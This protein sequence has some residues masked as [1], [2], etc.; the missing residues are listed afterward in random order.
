MSASQNCGCACPTPEVVEVPGTPGSDGA[1]GSDGLNAFTSVATNFTVP[2]ADGATP[3]TVPVY[4][5]T[6]MVVGQY[7]FIQSAGTFQVVSKPGASS[8]IL[9]YANIST[10][11]QAGST[12]SAGAG[13]S[14][15]GPPPS[16]ALGTIPITGGGTGATSKS[17]AQAALGLGQNGTKVSLAALSFAIPATLANIATIP[18][19]N[20]TVPANG[21]YLILAQATVWYQAVTFAS[22]RTLYIIAQDV[23]DAQSLI[24]M[25]RATGVHGSAVTYPEF[26]VVGWNVLQLSAGVELDLQCYLDIAQ[27]AGTAQITSALLAIIPLALT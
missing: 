26:D 9:T 19:A 5:S 11:T 20:V 14:P 16:V 13:V 25:L 7:V 10:N 2:A 22:S 17:G 1:S 8:V 27:G 3:V 12:I 4:N 18:G 15:S 23:T 6:W 24:T 21:L